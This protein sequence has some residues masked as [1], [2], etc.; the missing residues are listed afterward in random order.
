M[1]HTGLAAP[2]ELPGRR[3]SSAGRPQLPSRDA[4][5]GLSPLLRDYS[6]LRSQVPLQ[7]TACGQV[8]GSTTDQSGA[9]GRCVHIQPPGQDHRWLGRRP[10]SRGHSCQL[11][12]ARCLA[13]ESG[14]MSDTV[15]GKVTG[16]DAEGPMAVPEGTGAG[17]A[18]LSNRRAQ[19]RSAGEAHSDSAA[20]ASRPRFSR[21]STRDRFPF[22]LGGEP[23]GVNSEEAD[24]EMEAEGPEM[25]T[26]STGS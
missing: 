1:K 21:R 7:C 18:R 15:G 24:T 25:M 3:V 5:A 9:V 4:L 8:P 2:L 6:Y 26:S 20:A 22:F 12:A 10:S 23:V 16:S 14:R 19:V 17:V 11:V 13:S